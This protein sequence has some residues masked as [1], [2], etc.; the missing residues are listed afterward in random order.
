MPPEF[1]VI[2][3]NC[4]YLAAEILIFLGLISWA[5]PIITVNTPLFIAAERS[6]GLTSAVRVNWRQ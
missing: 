6:S 2:G 4:C 3:V 5:L 1:C